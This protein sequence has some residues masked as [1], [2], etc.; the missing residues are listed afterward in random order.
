[1]SRERVFDPDEP[2]VPPVAEDWLD[3]NELL[4]RRRLDCWNEGIWMI[5]CQF[6]HPLT[7]RE[8]DVDNDDDG[9]NE[10]IVDVEP[11]PDPQPQPD[12]LEGK[13]YPMRQR[14]RT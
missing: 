14:V 3:E 6:Q 8:F 5:T 12:P 11:E 4:E 7:M 1:M 13:R 2:M 9:N 10:E